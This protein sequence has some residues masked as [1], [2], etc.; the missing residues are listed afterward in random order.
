MSMQ[1]TPPRTRRPGWIVAFVMMSIAGLL[2]W[3]IYVL[4]TAGE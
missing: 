1:P 3:L 4:I 2:G